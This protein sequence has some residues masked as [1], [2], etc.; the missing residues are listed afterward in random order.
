MITSEQVKKI[1]REF[2]EKG[3]KKLSEELNISKQCVDQYA[4]RLRKLGVNIPRI[5]RG[6]SDFK[7]IAEELKKELNK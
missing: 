6:S 2:S 4:T 1:A 3:S 5:R 7:K